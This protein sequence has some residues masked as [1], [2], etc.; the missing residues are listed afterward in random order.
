MKLPVL[1]QQFSNLKSG[2]GGINLNLNQRAGI[3]SR[4]KSMI[5]PVSVSNAKAKEGVKNSTGANRGPGLSK[6][7]QGTNSSSIPNKINDV[8]KRRAVSN[9]GE[10]KI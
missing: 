10:G 2:S 9:V 1:F 6:F 8:M 5:N 4:S 3:M 7:Q